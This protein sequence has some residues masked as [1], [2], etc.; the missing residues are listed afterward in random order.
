LESFGSVRD[1]VSKPRKVKNK[2]G[3]SRCVCLMPITPALGRQNEET[4]QQFE[5][6]LDYMLRLLQN[7]WFAFLHERMHAHTHACTHTPLV[8]SQTALRERNYTQTPLHHREP[9][10]CYLN[11]MNHFPNHA[12]MCYC[13]LPSSETSLYF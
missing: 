6:S 9:M 5:G 2:R 3:K 4:C 8:D 11:I 13:Q 1:R 10:W 12:Q 7:V